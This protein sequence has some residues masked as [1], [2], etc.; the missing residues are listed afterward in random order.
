MS[1]FDLCALGSL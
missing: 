1:L